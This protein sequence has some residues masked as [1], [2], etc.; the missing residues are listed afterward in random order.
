MCFRKLI[1][2]TYPRHRKNLEVKWLIDIRDSLR[3][4]EKTDLERPGMIVSDRDMDKE[5]CTD[6]TGTAMIAKLPQLETK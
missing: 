2:R 3:N 6:H 4:S 1:E 5:A